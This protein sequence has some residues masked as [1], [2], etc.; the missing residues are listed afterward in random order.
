MSQT[1]LILEHL[2]KGNSLTPIEALNL[3][4][5]FRIAARVLE[6]KKQ[7]HNIKTET[8]KKGKKSFASYKLTGQTTLL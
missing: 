3:F 6:L 1:K 2:R 7:G 8:I 5:C 4:G